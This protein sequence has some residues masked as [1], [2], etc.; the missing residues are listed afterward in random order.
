[1]A[2]PNL[3]TINQM[4]INIAYMYMD[5][6]NVALKRETNTS[7]YD[8]S[9]PYRLWLKVWLNIITEE[10][11]SLR[12]AGELIAFGHSKHIGEQYNSNYRVLV[13][14]LGLQFTE[15][16]Y[17]TVI[18]TS[19]LMTAQAI[20]VIRDEVYNA[21]EEKK[22]P[23]YSATHVSNM[24][25][26]VLQNS[27]SNTY[28]GA[29]ERMSKST[30]PEVSLDK[31]LEIAISLE[32]GTTDDVPTAKD[33][34]VEEDKGSV[35]PSKKLTVMDLVS[36]AGTPHSTTYGMYGVKSRVNSAALARL[37]EIV[38]GKRVRFAHPLGT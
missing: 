27:L 6:A 35:S 2:A 28:V 18:V 7:L 5:K 36:R 11:H 15:T 16:E 19:L 20:H 4:S 10:I 38:E 14:S 13:D 26:G 33:V 3:I 17:F 1:M 21:L 25:L 30:C 8:V 22:D 37:E 34:Q 31:L 24:Y 12:K 32:P 29:L 23:N 9:K